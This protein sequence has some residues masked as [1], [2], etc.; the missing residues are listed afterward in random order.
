[1]QMKEQQ[2]KEGECSRSF[3]IVWWTT[4]V[5]V[6]VVGSVVAGDAAVLHNMPPALLVSVDP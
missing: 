2:R 1:M 4:V 5:A 6:A 3:C